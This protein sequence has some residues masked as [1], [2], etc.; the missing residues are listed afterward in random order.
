M[1]R[2][3][4][5]AIRD[6]LIWLAALVISGALGVHFWGSWT[7]GPVLPGLRG[8]LRIILGQPLARMR[9]WHGVQDALV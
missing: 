2:R 6:T 5:P 1:K 4:G 9:P 3:D 8:A 7:A